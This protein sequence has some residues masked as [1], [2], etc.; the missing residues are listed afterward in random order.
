ME[1]LHELIFPNEDLP[2]KMFLFEGENGNYYRDKHWH[3]S[4][5]IFAV[6][7]GQLDFYIGEENT[8]LESGEFIIVNSNEIHSIRAQKRN[9]TVVL[10][11]P[12]RI[13]EVYENEEGILCFSHR[14]E[15]K[16]T[17]VMGLIAQMYQIYTE[18][19][20]GYELMVQSLYYQLLYTMIIWYKKK[21]VSQEFIRAR[22]GLDRLSKI[23]TYIKENYQ[24]DLS[25]EQLASR[26]GYSAAYLSRMFH[27]Y[28]GINYKTYLSDVRLEKAFADLV[29]SEKEIGE[30]AVNHGFPDDRA[31]A[32][33]FRKK[34][35]CVPSSY[36]K[37]MKGQKS[38]PGKTSFR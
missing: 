34:Y 30:I 38:E 2:F 7:E 22:K 4:V 25:L 23:T 26:F 11:I 17:C 33:V 32:K 37:T 5:E 21:D 20:E 36:R 13:L 16:D 12:N 1:V 31:F 6:L 27:R 24:S 35:G 3:R 14:G 15:E 18:R 8:R 10:Q 9:K 29:H 28:A 19:A